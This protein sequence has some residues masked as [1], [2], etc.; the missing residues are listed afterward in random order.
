[1]GRLSR[2]LSLLSFDLVDT[3]QIL[4]EFL[5]LLFVCESVP[6]FFIQVSLAGDF[7]VLQTLNPAV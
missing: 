6:R 7:R 5:L 3:I 1:L 2:N 4:H